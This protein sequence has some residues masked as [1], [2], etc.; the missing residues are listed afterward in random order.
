MLFAN[1][2][3]GLENF[4]GDREKEN[5]AVILHK[6]SL[7]FLENGTIFSSFQSPGKI[8]SRKDLS[9]NMVRDGAIWSA[10]SFRRRT[11]I[12]S[13]PVALFISS[14]LRDVKTISTGISSSFNVGC[15]DVKSADQ[16]RTPEGAVKTDSK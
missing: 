6:A 12:P 3:V 16:V 1:D 4:G 8:P 14:C 9:S 11:G 2:E 10:V 7:S 15:E 13:D 5:R